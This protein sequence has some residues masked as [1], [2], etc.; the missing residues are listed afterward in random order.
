M[1]LSIFRFPYGERRRQMRLQPRPRLF[2]FATFQL[3]AYVISTSFRPPFGRQSI[4]AAQGERIKDKSFFP[5]HPKD[6]PPL[7]SMKALF[8]TSILLAALVVSINAAIGPATN[9]FIGNKF[10]SPDGFNRSG[11]LAGLDA[12]SVAFPGPLITGKKGDTFRLNVIDGLTNTSMLT[13]TSIHWHGL[14]Q[15]HTSWADGPAGVTQCPIAPGHSF[16]Y[17]FSAP[18]QAGTYWYHSHYSTQYCDG[19]RGP[20]VV[21]DPNDPYKSQYD[22]D[23]DSTV[24]TLADW[25]HTLAPS[26]GSRPPPVDSTLINGKGRSGNSTSALSVI[27]VQP[28]KRY[29]FRLISMSCDPNYI[30]SIDGHS[31]IIIEVDGQNVQPL[32]VDS[33]Q[34]FA[35][36][37]YSFIL[38]ANQQTAN[39]WIR[40]VGNGA[41]PAGSAVLHY[42]GAPNSEPTPVTNPPPSRNPLREERLSP[43]TNPA[44]PGVPSRGKADVNLNLQID[45]NLS[46]PGR[47]AVNNHTFIPPN[48]P[49]LL[50]ILNGAP[51]QNLLPEGSVYALPPNKVIELSLPGGTTG[52]PHPIHLHGHSFS[53]VRSANSSAYNYNN[54]V[55]RDV[56][57]IGTS[58]S[59]NVTIRFVT[60]NA[61]PWILHCHIDWHLEGGLAVVFAEDIPTI[62]SE[63]PPQAWSDLCPIF[64]ALPT[65]TFP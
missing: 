21:Y 4:L 8:S 36:Q 22:F 42:I 43:L 57:S 2:S 25:Y 38:Q 1:I 40:A 64:D 11:V 53:V 3:P 20:F 10:I 35:G 16:L 44:A 23:D 46:V 29:R 49:V 9:L 24:I 28:N 58:T 7:P 18:D 47:F 6:L 48:V 56:V 33:I 14:F 27:N 31:L 63:Q 62:A 34:I 55:R 54:P 59:D 41:T 12:D 15:E 17:Q 39:Y 52:S 61:G 5:L 30:F 45:F 13:S 50:Q 51:A 65:Q 60:D 26:A 37:R 32:T 19:L